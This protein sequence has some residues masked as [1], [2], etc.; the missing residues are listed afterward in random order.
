M[1]IRGKVRGSGLKTLKD[2][3][4]KIEKVRGSGFRVQG[5]LEVSGCWSVA[6]WGLI[7]GCWL[8]DSTGVLEY[9]STGVLRKT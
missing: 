6:L 5:L 4:Q 3:D 1:R 9:R 8:P 7:S 2:Q